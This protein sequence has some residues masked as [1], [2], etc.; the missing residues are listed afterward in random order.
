M[1]EIFRNWEK[2]VED[3]FLARNE[4]ER[5]LEEPQMSKFMETQVQRPEG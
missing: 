2:G 4:S 1:I 3:K 5:V